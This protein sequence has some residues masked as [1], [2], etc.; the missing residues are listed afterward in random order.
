MSESS[1]EF[2]PAE[3]NRFRSALQC[4]DEANA[5]DPNRVESSGSSHPREWLYSQWLTEW[6]LRLEPNASEPL[7]LAARAQHLRRWEIPRSLFPITRAGYLQWR[8]R[9]KK[10]HAQEAGK[11]L[12][13]LNYPEEVVASV[14]ALVLKKEFPTDAE[15]QVLE[16]ALCLVFLQHQFTDLAAKSSD[17]KMISVLQKSWK[18]MTPRAKQ[19]ALA[20]SYGPNEKRLIEQALSGPPSETLDTSAG[21]A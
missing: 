10:F 9:L 13:D 21:E 1:P 12:V 18:K 8:E 4:F 20:L 19:A 14:Q 2:R 6:V 5:R 15:C 11:I 3:P 17:Q 7:R 16:D